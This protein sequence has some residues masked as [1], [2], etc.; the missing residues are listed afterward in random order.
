VVFAL[1]ISL[2]ARKTTI[3]GDGYDFSQN[4]VIFSD[5]VWNFWDGI[6]NP[7]GYIIPVNYTSSSSYLEMNLT[8]SEMKR[9]GMWPVGSQDL[10]V[11]PGDSVHFTVLPKD[12]CHQS[13]FF[14]TGKNAAHYNFYGDLKVFME[15]HRQ[16]EYK[17]GSSI[18]VYKTALD[19]WKNIQLRF[20]E[21]YIKQH[22]VSEGFVKTI[23]A[24]LNANYAADLCHPL[25][26]DM[27]KLSELPNDYF[28]GID[29]RSLK[30]EN[31]LSVNYGALLCRYICCFGHSYSSIPLI[32]KQINQKFT[33]KVKDYLQAALV[34]HF[35]YLQKP[36]YRADLLQVINAAKKS[37]K[38]TAFLKSIQQ[39]ESY[40]LYLNQPISDN[41]LETTMLKPYGS[42]SCIT[43]KGLLQQ[44]PNRLVYIDIWA[45]TCGPCRLDISN[46]KE[47]KALLKENDATYLYFSIDYDESAWQKASAKDSVK[48]NQ[49]LLINGSSSPFAKQFGISAIPR[50]FLLNKDHKLVSANAPRPTSDRLK[51]LEEL[52]QS[53]KIQ[54][55]KNNTP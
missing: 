16:L 30:D 40:Y 9:M 12:S 42:D 10:Y 22:S 50:Y 21:Q 51:D 33:G 53:T 23:K 47:A 14:F 11:T 54:V 37:V 52:I 44:N 45:S 38:D 49:Y 20:L 29:E 24:Q 15:Q 26:S 13:R 46:S 17:R 8:K 36:D 19:S 7:W 2:N 34:G 6:S 43:L 1:P 27:I 4:N 48:L 32:E 25:N 18:A 39:S 41:V 28:N 31:L 5:M 3:I 35:A 55:I